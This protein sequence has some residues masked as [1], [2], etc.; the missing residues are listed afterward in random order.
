MEQ[1]RQEAAQRA[2][3]NL[4]GLTLE[5]SSPGTSVSITFCAF[6][7]ASHWWCHCQAPFRPKGVSRIVTS[8]GKIQPLIFRMQRVAVILARAVMRKHCSIPDA[9]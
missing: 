6:F 1:N 4:Q 3:N 7:H 5:Q 9:P 8:G 2:L